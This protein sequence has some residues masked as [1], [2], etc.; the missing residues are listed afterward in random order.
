M[1]TSVDPVELLV[2][3]ELKR[4]NLITNFAYKSMVGTFKKRPEQVRTFL[5]RCGINLINDHNA[6]IPYVRELL[7]KMCK[8]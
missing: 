2:L 1:Y 3:D 6:E 8:M 7:K 4:S 5:T